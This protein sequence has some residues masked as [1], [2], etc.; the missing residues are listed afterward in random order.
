MAHQYFFLEQENGDYLLQENGGRL[1]IGEEGAIEITTETHGV[2]NPLY[3][4]LPR[5]SQYVGK[6]S[7]RS[8]RTP[9]TIIKSDGV[10]NYTNS[11][12]IVRL[13]ESIEKSV[14]NISSYFDNNTLLHLP[15]FSFF[16]S[17]KTNSLTVKAFSHSIKVNYIKRLKKYGKLVSNSITIK[18]KRINQIISGIGIKGHYYLTSFRKI[19]V[20]SLTSLIK[21]IDDVNQEKIRRI[22][23]DASYDPFITPTQIA[24]R[25]MAETGYTQAQ[26]LYIMNELFGNND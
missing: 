21:A 24:N 5:Q 22:F 6:K 26:T 15:I 3:Q 20:K 13:A 4:R 18:P 17:N 25:I 12:S 14:L 11:I 16:E 19:H 2:Y 23:Q 8:H 9:I 1:I 7:K 10:R